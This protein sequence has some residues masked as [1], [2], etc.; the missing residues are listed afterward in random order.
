MSKRACVDI[1]LGCLSDRHHRPRI[2]II[3]L[4][5]SGPWHYLGDLQNRGRRILGT[6][7]LRK[8]E[9][10]GVGELHNV[11]N[12]EPPLPFSSTALNEGTTRITQIKLRLKRSLIIQIV[13]YRSSFKTVYQGGI[14]GS[15]NKQYGDPWVEGRGTYPSC[16][17]RL[18]VISA[19]LET[20]AV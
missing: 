9:S 12:N 19:I 4:K 20:N 8:C 1:P 10:S 15:K 11:W 14:P 16:A 18:G 13:L 2:R 5:E 17:S 7:R 6:S 3:A